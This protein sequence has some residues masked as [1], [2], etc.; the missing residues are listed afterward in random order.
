M[1]VVFAR[2]GRVPS[3]Q[4]PCSDVISQCQM[5]FRYEKSGYREQTRAT[6][7]SNRVVCVRL[8]LCPGTN[9]LFAIF[10]QLL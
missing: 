1:L 4:R 10:V 7:A 5:F 8:I 2:L 6:M 9:F 3:V